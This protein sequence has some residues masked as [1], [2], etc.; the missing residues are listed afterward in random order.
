MF[1][2]PQNYRNQATVILKKNFATTMPLRNLS[3]NHSV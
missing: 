1:L 2:T 3:F